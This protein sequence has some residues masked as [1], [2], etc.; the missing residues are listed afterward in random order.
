MNITLWE[1]IS[2]TFFLSPVKVQT[3]ERALKPPVCSSLLWKGFCWANQQPESCPSQTTGSDPLLRSPWV[4]WMAYFP[5]HDIY[6]SWFL[7]TFL[8]SSSHPVLPWNLEKT[9]DFLVPAETRLLAPHFTKGGMI[10]LPCSSVFSLFFLAGLFEP[11]LLFVDTVHFMD[12][13][14]FSEVQ[15]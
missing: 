15:T 3:A 9:T 11:F 6:F 4:M 1:L 14:D 12:L 7:R 2:P 10:L 5:P 13:Y 8:R